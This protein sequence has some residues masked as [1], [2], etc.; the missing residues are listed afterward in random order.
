MAVVLLVGGFVFL[1][2]FI[3]L[4]KYRDKEARL[5]YDENIVN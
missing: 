2:Y 4:I 5:K 1:G 3:F